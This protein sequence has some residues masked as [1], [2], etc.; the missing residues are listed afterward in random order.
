MSIA[1]ATA[2]LRTGGR[3]IVLDM[4]PYA[5]LLDVRADRDGADVALFMPFHERLVGAPGRLHGGAVAGLLELAGIARLLVALDGDGDDGGALPQ[6]KLITC[7]VDYLREGGSRG[8]HATAT[9]TRQGR[10]I[11][12]L[13]AVAWQYDHSRPIATANLNYLLDRGPE[14]GSTRRHRS[15]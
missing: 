12:N 9:L 5:A 7:T 6:L 14:Q 15:R 1:D 11:A 2:A 8:T 10:R 4:L 13:Q 3:G